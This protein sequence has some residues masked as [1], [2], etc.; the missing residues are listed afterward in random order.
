MSSELCKGQNQQEE[1]PNHSLSE[2]LP[3]LGIKISLFH[4]FPTFF[5]HLPTFP[6]V[7]TF[8]QFQFLKMQN[9]WFIKKLAEVKESVSDEQGPGTKQE[10][11]LLFLNQWVCLASLQTSVS[12]VTLFCFPFSCFVHLLVWV[13]K[14]RYLDVLYV[15]YTAF[16]LFFWII[17][18]CII[19][20][21]PLLFSEPSC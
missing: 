1:S 15:H 19:H 5:I 3:A 21:P 20:N 11:V 13:N 2:R 8:L 9:Y 6:L 14:F 4:S 12:P 18:P 16:C 7:S 10:T 17:G